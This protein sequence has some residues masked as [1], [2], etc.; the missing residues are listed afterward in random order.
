MSTVAGKCR[1]YLRRMSLPEAVIEELNLDDLSEDAT[2][3]LHQFMMRRERE[4]AYCH[5]V[6]PDALA[7][8]KQIRPRAETDDEEDD[9]SPRADI[10][11]DGVIVDDATKEASSEEAGMVSPLDLKEQI[12]ALPEGKDS[13]RVL[14]NSPG[15][16]FFA[17]VTMADM[18]DDLKDVA[19][20]VRVRGVAASAAAY[21]ALRIH[22]ELEMASGSFLMVHRGTV[23]GWNRGDLEK[24]DSM[25]AKVDAEQVQTVYAASN[26]KSEADAIAAIDAETWYSAADA[27]EAG[28]TT[29]PPEPAA[30]NKRKKVRTE[31]RSDVLSG[32]GQP[33]PSQGLSAAG[34]RAMLRAR[35]IFSK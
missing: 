19:I 8:Y 21:I 2:R 15:G 9:G 26:M 27:W 1:D 34:L 10:V 35:Q 7:K 20:V 4:S 22:D 24:L 29:S 33:G 11:L 25:L 14:L 12:D 31:A 28:F 3:S 16:S 6:M 17:A 18:L 13:V 23:N 30:R 32:L 5:G